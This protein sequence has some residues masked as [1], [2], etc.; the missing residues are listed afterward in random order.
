MLHGRH[1]IL[2]QP[3]MSLFDLCTAS[4]YKSI[5]LQRTVQ[6]VTTALKIYRVG[7]QALKSCM[8][9]LF[10]RGFVIT[11]RWLDSCWNWCNR[12]T[13]LIGRG[14]F[15]ICNN[16]TVELNRSAHPSRAL[17]STQDLRLY[18]KKKVQSQETFLFVN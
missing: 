9:L 8:E 3:R 7:W 1:D 12:R 13:F 4:R 14:S 5:S 10:Y 11:W 18:T 16:H 6:L 15:I 2:A 17:F